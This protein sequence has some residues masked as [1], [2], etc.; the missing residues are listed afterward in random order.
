MTAHQYRPFDR[1]SKWLVQ[2]HGDS[3]LRLAKI[4]NIESWRPAQA[5]VVVPWLLPDG[6]L[7]VR[8]CRE[9]RDQLFPT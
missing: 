3:M 2:H 4:G 6:L 9:D 7:E 5:G 1:S 8:V